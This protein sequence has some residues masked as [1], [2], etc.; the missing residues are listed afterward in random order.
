MHKYGALCTQDLVRD[1]LDG[2]DPW[3]TG[4]NLGSS[5]KVR[6]AA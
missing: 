3:C 5:K 2:K 4:L 6:G 1:T